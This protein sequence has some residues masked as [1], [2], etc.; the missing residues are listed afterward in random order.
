MTDIDMLMSLATSF[1]FST[2][3]FSNP[4]TIS[5]KHHLYFTEMSWIFFILWTVSLKTSPNGFYPR[6][7]HFSL[8]R[9]VVSFIRGNRQV[10]IFSVCDK[11]NLF[12]C[13]SFGAVGAGSHRPHEFIISE[14][15]KV[16]TREREGG[17]VNGKCSWNGVICL[18]KMD[19]ARPPIFLFTD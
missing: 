2:T 1:L 15:L 10:F 18:I 11:T 12:K 4:P 16:G 7:I 17:K 13:F 6:L 5:D 19:P 9:V 14:S 8:I 3:P